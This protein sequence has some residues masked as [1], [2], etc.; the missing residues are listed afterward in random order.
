M[1]EVQLKLNVSKKEALT[2]TFLALVFLLILAGGIAGAIYAFPGQAERTQEVM[3]LPLFNMS[4]IRRGNTAVQDARAFLRIAQGNQVFL[5]V[6]PKGVTYFTIT[7]GTIFSHHQPSEEILGYTLA[8][9]SVKD[10]VA[11]RQLQ[12]DWVWIGVF[13]VFSAIL[14][15]VWIGLFWCI[16]IKAEGK[17]MAP[18]WRLPPAES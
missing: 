6:E 8:T 18:F 14:F 1:T 17:N 2:R 7:G 15:L 10:G 11:T 3:L 12:R 13:T 5:N 16:I 4:E 9:S